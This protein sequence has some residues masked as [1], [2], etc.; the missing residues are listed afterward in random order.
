MLLKIMKNM[1]KAQHYGS[2][3]GQ[4]VEPTGTYV[5]EKDFDRK[6]DKPWVEGQAN[7]SNPLVIDVD[8][9]TLISYKYELA[10]KYKA[11]GKRLTEK[12]MNAGYDA[13]ITMRNGSTGEIILFPNCKF[14]LG[15]LDENKTMIKGL[16]RESLLT[17]FVGQEMVS[18]KRYFSMTDEEKK[19]YLPHEYPYEFETFLYE[20]G[21]ETDIEGEP[22]EITDILFDKNPKLYNQFAQWLYDKIMNH[23]LNINDAD[24]PAWSF[25]DNPR[26]VKNQWLIHFTDDAEGI[27]RQGFKYGVDE[28]DKLAL[29]THLGEFE[30]K[31]GGYN[32]AY[33]IERY[34]RYAHSNHG[35]GFKYGKEAVIFRASGMELWHY[36]DE[37]P[38]VIFYGN[39]AKSI[40]PITEGE[41]HQWA[42]KSV[43]SGRS[44]YESDEFDDIVVWIIRN[45]IQYRKQF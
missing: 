4:D 37:E 38:Q 30:K 2:M 13:I 45:F 24:L 29:T 27:A 6:L 8:D 5:L 7:I 9:D 1:E 19:S 28:I 36:G 31:Y 25:F 40:I 10:K 3:F 26:L 11:K 14:M 16:L 18:L 23:D 33:D 22:Y 21:L 39:T 42:V 12:L 20:E 34:A 17:E 44:L 15:G 35:R 41:E 32:F 43:K